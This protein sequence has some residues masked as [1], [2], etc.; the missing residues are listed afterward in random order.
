MLA[1]HTK[2]R[3]AA[4]IQAP[5]IAARRVFGLPPTLRARRGGVSWELDLR[6]GIDFA[7]WLL[8]VFERRTVAAYSR[9]VRAGAVVFDIGANVGAHTLLLAD[10]VGVTGQVYAFE[11]VCWAIDKLRRNL[12]LNPLLVDRVQAHQLL[13]TH[14]DTAAVPA[15]IHASWPLAADPDVHPTLR[16]RRLTT[17]GA[18]AITLDSFVAANAISRLDFVKLDVDGHECAVFRG[19]MNTLRRFRPVIVTELSPY[20]LEEGG[21]SL[22]TL[23][24]QISDLGYRLYAL[25]GETSL[26]LDPDA[27]RR[28][29][30][31]GGGIN[32]LALAA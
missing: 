30:P 24:R 17:E 32:A 1:T 29:I 10:L 2:I 14:S 16:A 27:L 12:H 28:L 23:L 7:I 15:G 9:H 31:S 11:P 26:P 5:V 13:L 4:A 20:V 8:G 25:D 3:I 19:A 18:W 6:E 21:D 22:E